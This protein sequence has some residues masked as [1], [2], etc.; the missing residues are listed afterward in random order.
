MQHKQTTTTVYTILLISLKPLVW[1]VV[2]QTSGFFFITYDIQYIYRPKV[3]H[4]TWLNNCTSNYACRMYDFNSWSNSIKLG[5]VVW[6][7]YSEKEMSDN[8]P[9]LFSIP[10]RA[11]KN[12]RILSDM[13]FVELISISETKYL[14]FT[15]KCTNWK[16]QDGNYFVI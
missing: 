12:L 6:Y 1:C 5:N 4:C 8:F 9:F 13:G 14:R 2:A 16:C 11:Y 7:Q 15:S 10:K 3:C